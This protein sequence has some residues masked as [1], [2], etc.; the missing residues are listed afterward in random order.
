MCRD[1]ELLTK[2]F[3]SYVRPLLEYNTFIWS[4]SD[5]GNITSIENVQRRFTKKISAVSHLSYSDRLRVLGL[6]SLEYR[7]LKFDTIMFYKIV[8][9]LV[10][11]DRDSLITL[12]VTE[13][14]TRNSYLKIFKPACMSRI[15]CNFFLYTMYK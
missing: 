3:T 8:H 9:N 11:V 15:R 12:R 4:P 7:R 2:A 5:V 1:T 14:Q 13:T 6:E 10:D